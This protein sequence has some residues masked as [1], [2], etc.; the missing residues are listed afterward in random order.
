MNATRTLYLLDIEN[1]CG[2]GRLEPGL[3]ASR[4]RQ[5]EGAVAPGPADQMIV[6]YNPLNRNAVAFGILRSHG[7][8]ERSGPDGA[9]LALEEVMSST[10][11]RRFDHIVLA[12]GDHMFAPVVARL[13]SHGIGTT[14]IA[15][16]DSLAGEL[17]LASTTVLLM[18]E[19]SRAA[20]GDAA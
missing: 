14:V 5:L 11:A 2:T 8:V 17:R 1:M 9:D 6:G 3:V 7:H 13:A 16:A 18:Q 10:H 12:S 19:W 4:V 15:G 20:H